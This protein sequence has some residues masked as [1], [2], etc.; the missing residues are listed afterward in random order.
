MSYITESLSNGEIINKIFEHHW[1]VKFMIFLN[2]LFGILTIIWIIP[3]IIFWLRW[4]NTENGVT[5]KRV[6]SKHGIISRVTD[7]IRLNA[8]E[9]IKIQQSIW[10][11]IFGYGNVIISGR[12]HGE[13]IIKWVSDPLEVKRLIENSEHEIQNKTS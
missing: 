8:I 6:I 10:G 5:N 12:G 3:A 4:K 11:R 1:V 13:V 9:S 2:F 7:E